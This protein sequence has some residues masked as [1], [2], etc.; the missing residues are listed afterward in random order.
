M[1]WG[2]GVRWSG[3]KGELGWGKGTVRWVGGKGEVRWGGVRWGGVGEEGE[4]EWGKGCGGV[5]ERVW[6]GGGRG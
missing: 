5:G 2:K 4:V 6:W 1:G 3:G